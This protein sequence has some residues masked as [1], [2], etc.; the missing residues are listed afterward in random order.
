MNT[1]NRK[2]Q[3]AACLSK[4]F[5][6]SRPILAQGRYTTPIRAAH[7][8]SSARP[9]AGRRS[10]SEAPAAGRGRAEDARRGASYDDVRAK[11]GMPASTL[12]AVHGSD[13]EAGRAPL[14]EMRQRQRAGVRRVAIRAPDAVVR[15]SGVEVPLAPD[16]EGR[17]EAQWHEY[18]GG[19]RKR[20]SRQKMLQTREGHRDDWLQREGIRDLPY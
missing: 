4:F 17:V 10:A 5:P 20:K 9:D 2:S 12:R 11:Y 18:P 8:W 15:E 1:A 19:L 7:G 6:I 14:P 3:S 16:T 13:E